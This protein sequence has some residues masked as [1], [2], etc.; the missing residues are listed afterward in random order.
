MKIM[1]I[2][3]AL[4]ASSSAS[5]QVVV[6]GDTIKIE[7]RAVRLHGIDAAELSQECADGWPAGRLAADHLRL[8]IDGRVTVCTAV[9]QDRYRRTVAVCRADGVDIGEQMVADGMAW[10]FIRY[11]ADYTAQEEAA[12]SAGRGIHRHECT[13]AWIFRAERYDRSTPRSTR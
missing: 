3:F 2:V 6:D 5:A 10:A 13:P 1:L 4:C 12:R 11:S 8:L 9:A 7:G